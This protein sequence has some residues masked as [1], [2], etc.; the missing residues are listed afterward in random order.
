MGVLAS[1]FSEAIIVRLGWV[2]L[3]FIWQ[4]AALA[5]L[6]ALLM[7]LLRNRSANS[8]YLLGCLGLILMIALPAIT[9]VVIPIPDLPAPAITAEISEV[10]S[11]LKLPPVSIPIALLDREPVP[12]LPGPSVSAPTITA[13]EP[14]YQGL[15]ARCE[16]YLPWLVMVWLAGVMILSLRLLTGWVRV[17]R[18]KQRYVQ[19]AAVRWQAMVVN[20]S[21]R[22]KISRPVQLLSSSITKVPIAI[23]WLKP[24]ILLPASALTGLTPEQVQAILA[25]ELA[26]IRRYDYLI[27]LLQTV[28]ET[29]LFYHPAIWWLSHR[30]RIERENCCDDLAVAVC[31]NKLT[32]ARALTQAAQLRNAS[33]HLAVAAD[34]CS[35]LNRIQRL[36][37]PSSSAGFQLGRSMAG[38]LIVAFLIVLAGV[39]MPISARESEKSIDTW[40]VTLSNGIQVELVGV[41]NH[42]S[43]DGPWWKPDGSKLDQT[44]Y[45]QTDASLSY[46]FG[47]FPREDM[48]EFAIRMKNLPDEPIH[49]AFDT[50]FTN[51]AGT[52]PPLKQGKPLE[53]MR[54]VASWS[55]VKP[56][57]GT[58]QFAVAAGP[59]STQ[60]EI[61][62]TVKDDPDR[63]E[64][65]LAPQFRMRGGAVETVRE[66]VYQ[67]KRWNEPLYY[68]VEENRIKHDQSGND[69]RKPGTSVY[70][71][72]PGNSRINKMNFWRREVHRV[73]VLDK[74]G[75]LREATDYPGRGYKYG[76]PGY[77]GMYYGFD[78]SWHEID[79]ILCQSRPYHWVEFSNVS[80]NEGTKSDV[81]VA[82]GDKVMANP[83]TQP[84]LLPSSIMQPINQG[85]SFDGKDDYLEVPD[86]KPA[87]KT[88]LPTRGEA[89]EG[90]RCRLRKS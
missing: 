75:R 87:T 43:K 68:Y 57:T 50:N 14:W 69:N 42:P 33:T 71:F 26:H 27:N 12:A 90:V 21:H 22:L 70:I 74:Q 78:L 47:K 58:I 44:P 59:W 20:L 80:L 40:N 86:T 63:V 60:K 8:R 11:D 6:L 4:G 37:K 72:H 56:D 32:Y 29:L 10:S 76:L 9:Y 16:P 31:G 84:A 39:L 24:V 89:Y 46:L 5:V 64:P 51:G 28:I 13:S 19:P 41:S 49:T 55:K 66:R 17:Q 7:L 81:K 54:A 34:G 30:I 83:A 3:H 73:I 2:L 1:V 45:D 82:L 15:S 52:G 35:L 38:V 79:R 61:I 77:W 18:I 67:I 23:G 53:N 25:H 62:P 85:M 88:D 65:S 48:Y 36:L